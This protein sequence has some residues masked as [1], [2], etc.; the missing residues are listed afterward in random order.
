MK[1]QE[2]KQE[3]Y[4][5]TC[6]KNT[7]DLKKQRPELVTNRDLRY[8]NQW[9]AILDEIKL[10]RTQGLDLSLTDLEESEKML[11]ESLFTVGHLAGLSNESIELDWQRIKL[12]N[13]FAD[14]HI[15]EL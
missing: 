2:I 8:K 15:E 5:L 13:Q 1:L 9:V 7:K 6:T 11:K 10:L 14:I 3:I 12:E 4:Q